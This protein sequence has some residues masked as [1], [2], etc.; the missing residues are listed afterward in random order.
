MNSWQCPIKLIWCGYHSMEDEN[1]YYIIVTNLSCPNCHAAGDV[2]LP[3]Q[4]EDL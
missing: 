3:K 1:E 4:E 2:Y